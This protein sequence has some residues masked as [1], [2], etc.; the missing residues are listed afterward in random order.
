MQ[1][2]PSLL[3]LRQFVLCPPCTEPP[4][5]CLPS[6][7]GATNLGVFPPL[8]WSLSPTPY[9]AW[10]I[11][12]CCSALAPG[13]PPQR[14]WFRSDDLKRS[15]HLPLP[16]GVFPLPAPLSCCLVYGFIHF[17]LSAFCGPSVTNPR[18]WTVLVTVH[19]GPRPEPG[20]CWLLFCISRRNE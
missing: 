5:C 16:V 4:T 13:P 6:L 7:L 3:G 1:K 11:S 18:A 10:L 14:G 15:P 19:P 17:L 9:L 2:A 20:M 8:G 12:S